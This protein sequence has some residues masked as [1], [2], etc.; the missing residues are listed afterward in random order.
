MPSHK[1]NY[2]IKLINGHLVSIAK[3]FDGRSLQCGFGKHICYQL[4][5]ISYIDCISKITFY[6]CCCIVC[7]SKCASKL[8]ERSI[9]TTTHICFGPPFLSRG[10]LLSTG[11][12]LS[13]FDLL[14][15]LGL[16]LHLFP[17]YIWW[18]LNQLFIK[19]K[20]QTCLKQTKLFLGAI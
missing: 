2:N 12:T 14:V 17:A 16:L 8:H 10:G 7:V 20:H 18:E 6:L 11:A 15:E 5:H 4:D 19:R 3:S 1:E 13:S 9:S